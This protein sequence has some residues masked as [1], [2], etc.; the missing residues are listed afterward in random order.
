MPCSAS[1]APQLGDH[2]K[3]ISL[4]IDLLSD[5]LPSLKSC[6][7]VCRSWTSH[8]RTHIFYSITLPITGY[9][10]IDSPPF[11]LLN[12]FQKDSRAAHSVRSAR[13]LGP[14]SRVRLYPSLRIVRGVFHF[15]LHPNIRVLYLSNFTI[16]GFLELFDIVDTLPHIEKLVVKNPAVYRWD[17][18]RHPAYGPLNMPALRILHWN[19]DDVADPAR[20]NVDLVLEHAALVDALCAAGILSRLTFL[21]LRITPPCFHQWTPKFPVMSQSLQHCTVCVPVIEGE[22]TDDQQVSQLRMFYILISS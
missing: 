2:D 1:S 8:A 17:G 22:D 20:G 18:Q 12:M 19:D 4:I 9:D 7:L 5:D 16:A 10:R 13:L 3:I 14:I 6:A 15:P 21:H 11:V